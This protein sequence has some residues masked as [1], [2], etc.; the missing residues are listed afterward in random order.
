MCGIAGIIDFSAE[1]PSERTLRKMLGV[2]RHRGPD[3]FGI[4]IDENAGIASSRLSI[5][6]L[7]T[8]NQPICNEDK[9]V[10]VVL[11]GEIFNY[12]ELRASLEAKGHRFQ[13][14]SDT[15]VLVHLYEDHG[16]ECLH[17]LNGQFGFAIWDIR[18]R[19]LLLA[20]DRLGIR[21]LYYHLKN[22]RLI[23]GS[24]IKTLFADST[25]PRAMNPQGLS[26]IFTFWATLGDQTVFQDVKQ[27]SPGHVALFN[28]DGFKVDQ[29]WQLSFSSS[30]GQ[31]RSL[32]EWTEELRDLLHD[33]ARLRLRADVPVGAYL[34]GGLD[35][36]YIS[37]L[38]KRDFNNRLCTFSVTFTDSQ[39]DETP[40]QNKAIEALQTDHQSVR[41]SA[42]RIWAKP[43][44]RSSGTQKRLFSERPLPRFLCFLNLFAIATSKSC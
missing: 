9:S 33:A 2:M 31:N 28:T 3:A 15:E 12:T 19:L 29:Y 20:R 42:K 1:K 23:F 43:F 30:Y 34:S 25:V 21:P 27:L 4:Y 26:E 37:S 36:T 39:F 38:V 41:C 5:I 11:N 8:G 10:W 14:E 7:N 16:A 44:L 17:Q 24:E 35:S 32:D 40:F 13:A 18:K 6:D 22:N